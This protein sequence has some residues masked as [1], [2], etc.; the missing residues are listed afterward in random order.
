MP[1]T[2]VALVAALRQ[3][4]LAG[5]AFDVFESELLTGKDGAKLAGIPNSILTPQIAGVTEESNVRVS[6]L[7]AERVLER[8]ER[9]R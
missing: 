4:R 9:T 2:E 8:L 3:G 1:L 5:A 7:I 6:N